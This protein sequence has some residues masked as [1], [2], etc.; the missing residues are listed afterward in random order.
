MGL[1]EQVSVSVPI[2]SEFSLHLNNR[3][4]DILPHTFWLSGYNPILMNQ[5]YRHPCSKQSMKIQ[6][7]PDQLSPE[8][9][10]DIS[11]NKNRHMEKETFPTQLYRHIKVGHHSCIIEVKNLNICGGIYLLKGTFDPFI[12]IKH[13]LPL[14]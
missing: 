1:L 10:I 13:H 4:S 9:T 11:A 8:M 3:N 12:G 14:Q 5:Q 7:H 2:P 6:Q